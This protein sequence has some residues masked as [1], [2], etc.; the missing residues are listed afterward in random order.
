MAGAGCSI[1]ERYLA[2]LAWLHEDDAAQKQLAFGQM[3]RDWAIGTR[4]FKKDLIREHKQ[5]AESLRAH[6]ESGREIAREL[7]QERLSAYLAVL[8]KSGEEVRG[9]AKGAPW[10][11]AVAAAMKTSTTASNPWLTEQLS[12][13]ST[14]RLSRLVSACRADPDAFRPYVK[15]LAKCKV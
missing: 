14:F 9:S 13:G 15:A 7:W 5:L 6:P 3:S 1:G 8:K 10:K 4:E 12:M 2:Y 11:V